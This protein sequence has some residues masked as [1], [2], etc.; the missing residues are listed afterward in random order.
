MPSWGQTR[1][2]SIT[3][4]SAPGLVTT[5]ALNQ[6]PSIMFTAAPVRCDSNCNRCKGFFFWD[7]PNCQR[8][9]YF[10]MSLLT[11]KAL[12]WRN[13]NSSLLASEMHIDTLFWSSLCW[14]GCRCSAI[15]NK[16]GELHGLGSSEYAVQFWNLESGNIRILYLPFSPCVIVG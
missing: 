15:Q 11:G 2:V 14:L 5:T 10:V 3:T 8:N 1:P 13:K 16:V 9:I 4:S 7:I 12:E 6:L